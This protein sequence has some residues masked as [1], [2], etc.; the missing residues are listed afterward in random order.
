MRKGLRA[1]GQRAVGLMCRLS[2]L[3]AAVRR[4]PARLGAARSRLP[5]ALALRARDARANLLVLKFGALENCCFYR[6]FSYAVVR[7]VDT[8]P[9]RKLPDKALGGRGPEWAGP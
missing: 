3:G 7:R 6:N 5:R 8:A 1:L 2:H 4:R 9:L